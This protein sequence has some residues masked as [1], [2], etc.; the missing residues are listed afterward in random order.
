MSKLPVMMLDT[1]IVAPLPIEMSVV[2]LPFPCSN[3]L[4]VIPDCVMCLPGPAFKTC[5]TTA[6]SR[7]VMHLVKAPLSLGP[8]ITRRTQYIEMIRL[9]LTLLLLF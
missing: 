6:R 2:T 8:V 4:S 1:S 3:V 5:G 9:L 7:I